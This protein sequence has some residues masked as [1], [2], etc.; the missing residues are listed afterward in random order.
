M[1]KQAQ[2]DGDRDERFR[3]ELYREFGKLGWNVPQSDQEVRAAEEWIAANPVRLPDRLRDLPGKERSDES[4]GL[5]ERYLRDD[6][7]QPSIDDSKSND[8]DRDDR[9]LDR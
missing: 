5:L 6:G 2:A 1:T 7:R 8:K 3:P 9:D 4:G